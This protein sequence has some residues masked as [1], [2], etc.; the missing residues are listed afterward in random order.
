M[1]QAA[2]AGE[3]AHGKHIWGE[4]GQ[5]AALTAEGVLTFRNEDEL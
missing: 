5:P 4:G 2:H 1:G 3:A